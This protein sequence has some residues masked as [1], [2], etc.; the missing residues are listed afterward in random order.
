MSWMKEHTTKVVKQESML[1]ELQD[2]DQTDQNVSTAI[3]DMHV[4]TCDMHVFTC[5]Y[6]PT[7]DN[8]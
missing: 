7:D 3:I 8:R 4:F 2:D 5:S 6:K 1:V